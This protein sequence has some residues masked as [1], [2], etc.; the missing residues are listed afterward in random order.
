MYVFFTFCI[1]RYDLGL[2][3]APASALFSM[4]SYRSC[5]VVY[6]ERSGCDVGPSDGGRFDN[7]LVESRWIGGTED[8]P[9][10]VHRDAKGIKHLGVKFDE[11][12]L[13][14]DL[15]HEISD[16]RT[17]IAVGVS[18]DLERIYV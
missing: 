6:R 15:W 12:H 8:E 13:F 5:C 1:V 14:M 7:G 4:A 11:I 2:H 16:V 9:R 10:I 18:S 3:S 17:N